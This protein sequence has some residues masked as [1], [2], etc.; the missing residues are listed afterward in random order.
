MNTHSYQVSDELGQ[1]L[2]QGGDSVETYF[3]CITT[4]SIH[5]GECITRC[6]EEL[7]ETSS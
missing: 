3:E 6:V 1:H 2:G 7:R 4:C 5:D